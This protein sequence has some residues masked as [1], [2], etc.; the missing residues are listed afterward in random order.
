[1]KR[2]FRADARSPGVVINTAD[3]TAL[4]ARV[5]DCFR[6]GAG[7]AIA[8]LNLDHLVKLRRDKAFQD[9]YR[10]H[11]IIVADG[12]PVVWLSR[13]A[14]Q[15]V[16]L[17]PGADLVLPLAALAAAHRAPVALLGST[18]DALAG[19]AERL[20]RSTPDLRIAARLVPPFGFDPEGDVA[21]EMIDSIR[22]SGARLVFL[23]LGAPRQEKFAARC[24][25]ELPHV[26]FASIGAGLDFLAGNQRRAPAW[27]RRMALEWFWRM[28]SQPRRLAMRYIRCALIMPDL[29]AQALAARI[30]GPAADVPAAPAPAAT[31][32]DAEMRLRNAS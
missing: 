5:A 17:A 15:R 2:Q 11:D 4:L 3:Q 19:A 26:G 10:R 16:D 9:A 13:L 21:G 31:A 29:A 6:E 30:A 14:G 32:T 23:A 18:R 20:V 28:T 8:T 1:V 12:N 27:V 7:F 25:R 22:R 24:R